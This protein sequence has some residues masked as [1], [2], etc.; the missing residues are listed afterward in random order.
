VR[1]INDVSDVEPFFVFR[2]TPGDLVT[3]HGRDR[4]SFDMMFGIVIEKSADLKWRWTVLSSGKIHVV[5]QDRLQV[6]L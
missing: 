1:S 4:D 5:H 2:G 3:V 6:V